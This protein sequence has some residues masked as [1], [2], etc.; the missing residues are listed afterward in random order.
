MRDDEGEDIKVKEDSDPHFSITVG[1]V[2]NSYESDQEIPR[3]FDLLHQQVK[4]HNRDCDHH[5]NGQIMHEAI[6]SAD[7]QKT[8]AKEDKN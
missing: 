5:R 8:T 7:E 4:R 6:E 2:V 1:K 3:N